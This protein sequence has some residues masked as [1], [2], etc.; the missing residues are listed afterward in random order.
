MFL[1]ETADARG[2]KQSRALARGPALQGAG[3]GRRWAIKSP[4]QPLA[5]Q[6]HNYRPAARISKLSVVTGGGRAAGGYG[7][8]LTP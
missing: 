8:L 6:K 2:E 3:F 7:I 5:P 4:H 1:G